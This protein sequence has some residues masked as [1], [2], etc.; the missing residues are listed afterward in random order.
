MRVDLCHLF[1][2]VPA[3][4]IELGWVGL[5]FVGVVGF[6][7]VVLARL[8]SMVVVHELQPNG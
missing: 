7:C 8:P 1:L 3:S 4:D 6:C 5:G 2:L